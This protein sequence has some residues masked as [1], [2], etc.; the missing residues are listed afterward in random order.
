M[1]CGSLRQ[2]SQALL[3]SFKPQ[4]KS[5]GGKSYVPRVVPRFSI[6]T[7]SVGARGA[8]Q[9]ETSNDASKNE[10]AQDILFCRRDVFLLVF[11]RE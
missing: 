10:N 4:Q 2:L 7:I 3:F 5:A 9:R 8:R 11:F 6:G 1:L